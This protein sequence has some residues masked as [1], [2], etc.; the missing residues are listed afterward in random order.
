MKGEYKMTPAAVVTYGARQ[1]FYGGPLTDES[2]YI[3]I[4]EAAKLGYGSME[5]NFKTPIEVDIVKD[6]CKRE[7][8]EC[9]VQEFY[10]GSKVCEMGLVK[11]TTPSQL[12]VIWYRG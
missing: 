3:R 12:K 1:D 4:M 2:L 9:E 10:G 7:N 8:F 5:F 11:P 6:F